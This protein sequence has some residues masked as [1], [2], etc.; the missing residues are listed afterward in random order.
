MP[1]HVA[2]MTWIT[3]DNCQDGPDSWVQELKTFEHKWGDTGPGDWGP[4]AEN[5]GTQTFEHKSVCQRQTDPCTGLQFQNQ[6]S[7][8]PIVATNW[9]DKHS[10]MN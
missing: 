9:L 4:R 5:F 10:G 7:K 1:G 8:R 3:C 2:L 6:K